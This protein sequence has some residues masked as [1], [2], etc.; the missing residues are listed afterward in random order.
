[1]K[2]TKTWPRRRMA[3]LWFIATRAG[4]H[5]GEVSP[6][7][8]QI[9]A[10]VL[11]PSRILDSIRWEAYDPFNDT[12]KIEGITISMHWLRELVKTKPPGPWFR[13]VEANKQNGYLVLETQNE[14]GKQ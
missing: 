12:L 7:W 5:L 14:E 4:V 8:L 2:P 1:M 3:V 11:I 9:L 13:V 10:C 6:R